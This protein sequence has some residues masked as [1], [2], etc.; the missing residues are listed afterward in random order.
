M[1]VSAL[2][3]D[4]AAVA[5][6][7]AGPYGFALAG[8]NALILHKVTDRHTQDVDLF[9]DEIGGVEAAASEVEDALA[10]AGFVIERRD[11]TGGLGDI[12]PGMGEGLAEWIVTA[13]SGAQVQLQMS[14]FTRERRP[15]DSDAGPVLDLDDVAAGKACALAARAE[16]RDYLDVAALLEHYT[17]DGLIA[18]ARRMD[19]GLGLRDFRDAGRRLDGTPDPAF[20]RYGLTPEQVTWVREQFADWPR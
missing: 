3:L 10:G 18:L 7:A 19:R 9:T 4:V 12:F 11:K 14:Y 2:H 13:P 1:P 20:T 17:T 15:V 8:G 16:V 5:L 6:R